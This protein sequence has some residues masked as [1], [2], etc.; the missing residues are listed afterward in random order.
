MA[1]KLTIQH[2]RSSVAG[3]TPSAAGLEVGEIAINFA[4]RAIFTKDAT[5]AVIELARDSGGSAAWRLDPAATAPTIRDDTTALQAGDE[6]HNTTDG[7]TYV[8]STVGGAAKWLPQKIEITYYYPLTNTATDPTSTYW[9]S[10]FAPANYSFVPN[11][12]IYATEPLTNTSFMFSTH[13]SAFSTSGT[14]NFNDP[15]ISSWDTSTVL[16]MKRMFRKCSVFNIDISGWDVSNVTDMYGLFQDATTF[17]QDISSWTIASAN[18]LSYMFGGAAAF[19]Q[20]IS[21]WDVSGVTNFS[22][23]FYSATAFNQ[24]ISSWVVSGATNFSGMFQFASSFD[25]PIG[26]WDMSSATTIASMFS[27]ASAFNQPLANWSATL[28]AGDM[29]R[30]F[31]SATAFNQDISSWNVSAVTFSNGVEAFFENATS[32]NQ[33]LSTWTFGFN[34]NPT[35]FSTGATA[36]TNPAWRPFDNSATQITT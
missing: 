23:M 17:N 6:Y 27:F 28:T 13:T 31:Q 18:T 25:Q 14:S 16:E 26:S 33:D 35:D 8:W 20:D 24:D 4:D 32:F 29:N 7:I 15:D 1:N 34:G 36:W 9:R 5:N 12:G 22:G 21:S 2:K 19:N 30:V 10:N 11:D 3:N